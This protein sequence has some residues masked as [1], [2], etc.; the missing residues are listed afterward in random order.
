[1]RPEDKE[2]ASR[3]TAREAAAGPEELAVRTMAE[4]QA[5]KAGVGS[6]GYPETLAAATVLPVV[7]EIPAPRVEGEIL[8]QRA[9]AGNRARQEA[10][11]IRAPPAGVEKPAI[12]ARAALVVSAR[13]AL[14]AAFQARS[15]EF[16]VVSVAF[17]ERWAAF[18]AASVEF[19]ARMAARQVASVVRSAT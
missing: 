5:R 12:V 9:A 1:L 8:E 4:C 2:P 3:E 19:P 15:E 13:P 6:A 10:G 18:L 7:V 11:E 14:G 16:L 17:R